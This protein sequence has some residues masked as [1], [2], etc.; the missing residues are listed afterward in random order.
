VSPSPRVA[1]RLY[2]ALRVYGSSIAVRANKFKFAS[3]KA[4]AR[5][6]KIPLY[7][8]PTGSILR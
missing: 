3:G 6:M 4:S 1:L 2:A 8:T 7:G 5:P